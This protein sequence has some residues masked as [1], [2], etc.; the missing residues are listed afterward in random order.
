MYW[1]AV[2]SARPLSCLPF[3]NASGS[4]LHGDVQTSS[5]CLSKADTHALTT[6]AGAAYNTTVEEI[7]LAALACSLRDWLGESSARVMVE[8]HGR[9]SLASIDVSRTVGWFTSIYPVLLEAPDSADV[10][11]IVKLTK[12]TLRRVPRQGI[13]YS[14]WK[15]GLKPSPELL[16]FNYLGNPGVQS[17]SREF[18]ISTDG[19]GQTVSPAAPRSVVLDVSAIVVNGQLQAAI[20]F[21][22]RQFAPDVIRGLLDGYCDHLTGVIRH[23]CSRHSGEVT[24]SDLTYSDLTLDEFDRILS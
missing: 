17:T 1:M 10:G 9:E 24:P 18:G 5:F 6:T 13:D 12:E 11:R 16:R 15:R 4:N 22:A 8:S 19:V 2:D 3:Q 23:C 20:N 14:L 21:S 7:L